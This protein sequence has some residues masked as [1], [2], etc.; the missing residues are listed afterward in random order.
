VI[1][2][3]PA[4]QAPGI[5]DSRIYRLRNAG[6][7]KAS[8]YVLKYW[9]LPTI[10]AF[11][12]AL[13]LL[14]AAWCA[15]AVVSR[16]AF[17]AYDVTGHVCT[18]STAAN[19]VA[20]MPQD[21]PVKI[22]TRMLCNPTGLIVKKGRTYDVNLVVTDGW[23]DGHMWKEPQEKGIETG[24]NGFGLDKMTWKMAPGLPYRRLISS[25]WFAT[26]LRIGE[27][28]FGEI[29]LT[30]ESDECPCPGPSTRYK[31]SFK[32]AKD[33]EVFAYVN[34]SVINWLGQDRFYRNNKGTANLTI[35]L[36]P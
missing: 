20:A 12:I 19:E 11:L 32:A 26:I 14:A 13:I 4:T 6:A 21:P 9:I 30:Y 28:G 35:T 27:S 7:Y 10:F 23:E 2:K 29:V 16:L 8:Y 25:N 15:V 34:D 24:P 18:A 3:T 33:G 1:W 31:A 17:L 5:P 22:D 36:K